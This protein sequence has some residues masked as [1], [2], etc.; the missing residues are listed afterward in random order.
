LAFDHAEPPIMNTPT[1]EV[2]SQGAPGRLNEDAWVLMQTGPLAEKIILAA[3]DGATTRLTPPPLQAYLNSLPTPIT[4]AAYS[5]RLVRDSIARQVGAG[6]PLEL[7]TLVLEA[8][9]DLGRDLI[10][11]MGA[12]TLAALCLPPDVLAPLAHDPRL[13][14]LGLP[15][16]VITLAEYDAAAHRLRYVHTGDTSLLVVYRDGRV[17]IPTRDDVAQN[18]NMLLRTTLKLRQQHPHLPFREL[19][20]LP[21]A[22]RFNLNSGL[23][24]NFV[25]EFGLP[26][27][28]QGV[29]VLDGLPELRYFLHAGDVDV[30]DAAYV[31]VITDGLEWPANARECFS[32]DAD[33]ALALLHQRRQ[34]MADQI[35]QH[36]LAGYLALLRAAEEE[37]GDHERY[38]RMKTHDDATG[39]LLRFGV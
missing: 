17:M 2:V 34:Y 29:G 9:A 25:D 12:L 38:P 28:S 13:V 22:T 31:C 5:A 6:M 21:E 39:V 16:S 33:H 10:R 36:G 26:Q 18:D 14:R 30:Q 1:F 3:I 20:R 23:R 11:L 8:N 4:P 35:G 32:D 37:D 7:R 15:A 19:V 27:P 24:H